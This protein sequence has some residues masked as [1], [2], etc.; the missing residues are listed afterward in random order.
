MRL[1]LQS[2]S[3]A[4]WCYRSRLRQGIPATTVPQPGGG[5]AALPGGPRKQPRQ[6]ASGSCTG[7][8]EAGTK[9]TRGRGRRRALR[10]WSGVAVSPAIR[11]KGGCSAGPGKGR[12]VRIREWLVPPRGIDMGMWEAC[13]DTVRC[14]KCSCEEIACCSAMGRRSLLSRGHWK[15]KKDRSPTV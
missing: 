5:V 15:L 4:G 8:G 3:A 1:R 13:G 6:S 14:Y 9:T 7:G 11:R 12:A 10:A 2:T